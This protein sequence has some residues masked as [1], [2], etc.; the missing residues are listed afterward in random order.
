M[1]DVHFT[2]TVDGGE[3][4]YRNGKAVMSDGLESAVYLSL[5]GGNEDHSGGEADEHLEWWGNKIENAES[6]KLRSRTQYVLR[7]LVAIP[8]NLR[9]VESAVREDLAW[10]TEEIATSVDAV[11]RITAP[12]RISLTVHVVIGESEYDFDFDDDWT[13]S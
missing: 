13:S 4:E 12:K 2:D 6:R 5:W 8:A 11:A 10:L 1:T 9:L 7:N 3:I